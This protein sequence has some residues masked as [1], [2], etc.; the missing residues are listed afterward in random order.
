[1]TANNF[2]NLIGKKSP[3][4][5]N[6][7]KEEKEIL[8]DLQK[9]KFSDVSRAEDNDGKYTGVDKAY[10]SSRNR[11]DVETIEKSKPRYPAYKYSN[12]GKGLLHEAVI[13]GGVPLFIKYENDDN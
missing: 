3:S 5:I 9:G 4:G 10:S 8:S 13:I 2:E 7:L 1:M 11:G 12:K 6:L